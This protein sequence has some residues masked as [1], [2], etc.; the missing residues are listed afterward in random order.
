LADSIH[1]FV[2]PAPEEVSPHMLV[3]VL[4]LVL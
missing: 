4:V 1:W 2:S 3:L